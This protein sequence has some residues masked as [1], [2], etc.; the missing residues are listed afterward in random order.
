MIDQN[1]DGWEDVTDAVEMKALVGVKGV[2]DN[3]KSSPQAAGLPASPMGGGGPLETASNRDKARAALALI[4]RVEP[5]LKRVRQL[6]RSALGGKG[7]A[8]LAE[9][10]PFSTGN[11]EYDAAVAGLTSLVRPATRTPGEGAMSDFESKLAVATLPNRWKRDAY[12]E[13]ALNGLQR[14]I[15]S[16]RQLYSRQLGLP[17]SPPTNPRNAAASLRRKYGLK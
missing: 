1:N 16:S 17:Q 7:L 15:D 12:N 11:Q 10:N 13:E 3:A 2:R 9:Y 8:G 14:L 5:Q 6:Q 4:E